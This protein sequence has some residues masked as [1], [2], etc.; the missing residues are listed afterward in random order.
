MF[1]SGHILQFVSSY[2]CFS[3]AFIIRESG[4]V[5]VVCKSKALRQACSGNNVTA[6]PYAELM[7]V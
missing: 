1:F 6:M 3:D 2:L 4:G 7:P 5:S